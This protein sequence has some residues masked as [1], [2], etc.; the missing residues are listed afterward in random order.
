ML[1][2]EETKQLVKKYFSEASDEQVERLLEE[3]TRDIEITIHARIR[4][5]VNCERIKKLS[6][7]D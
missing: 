2:Q 4:E 7:V 5:L 6:N 1:K 3:L